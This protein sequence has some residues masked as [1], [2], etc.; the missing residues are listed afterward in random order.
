MRLEELVKISNTTDAIF[1]TKRKT[2]HYGI[3][4]QNMQ[5]VSFEKFE[6]RL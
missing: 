5:Y 2:L 3:N 6:E 4:I 1:L